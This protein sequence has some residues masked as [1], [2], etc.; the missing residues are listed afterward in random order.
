[1]RKLFVLAVLVFL[2]SCFPIF[3]QT[4]PRVDQTEWSHPRFLEG[5]LRIVIKN[6]HLLNGDSLRFS[7]VQNHIPVNQPP[8]LLMWSSQIPNIASQRQ[9]K[10]QRIDPPATD[11]FIDS[12]NGNTIL[13]WNLSHKLKEG[14]SLII[15]RRFSYVC[16]DY[17]PQVNR[18]SVFWDWRHI[19]EPVKTFYTKSE[20]FLE[21][22]PEIKTLAD[23]IV[24]GEKN[25]YK[26]A[27]LLHHWVTA[28]IT[29]VYP[30][31]KRGAMAAYQYRSGDCGQFADLFIALA[32][33]LGIP[34]R[35]QAGFVF[36]K[37]RVSYHVWAEIYLP[38][39]GWFPVDPTRKNGFGFLDNK[40]LI[41]SVGMNIPLKFAPVWATYQNSEV[42]D[43]HTD[44]MQ[45]VTMVKSGFTADIN[46]EPIVLKDSLLTKF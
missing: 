41:A 42:E 37:E 32:R 31:E 7:N 19:P 21:L 22:T 30:P 13:F 16:Y 29:Y 36:S 17:K 1:M 33:S 27:R 8:T 45:L 14:D 46:T 10:I 35:L 23:S 34:A 44:F 24:R 38:N 15:D 2:I 12:E 39:K 40:R 9:V 25:P 18:D 6:I 20:P 26:Q 3:K 43:Q 5:E 28:N 11:T 4:L